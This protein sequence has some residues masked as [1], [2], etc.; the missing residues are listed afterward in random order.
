M[1][2]LIRLWTA[3]ALVRPAGMLATLAERAGP[4]D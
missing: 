3:Y 1:S 4:I 2:A